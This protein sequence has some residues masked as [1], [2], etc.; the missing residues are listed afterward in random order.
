[1][2][3]GPGVCMCI[4][5]GLSLKGAHGS[6]GG[7]RLAFC[8]S[9]AIKTGWLPLGILG[10]AGGGAGEWLGWDSVDDQYTWGENLAKSAGDLW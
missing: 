7:S 4:A 8:T 1:M 10:S 2:G 9:A 6:E 5:R 3:V